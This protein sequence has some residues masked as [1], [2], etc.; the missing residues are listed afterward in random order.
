FVGH[1]DEL[2]V[3]ASVSSSGTYSCLVQADGFT[4]LEGHMHLRLRGPPTIKAQQVVGAREGRSAVLRCQAR[5]VPHPLAVTWTRDGTLINSD[6]GSHYHVTQEQQ[7]DGLVSTLIINKTI[8]VDFAKYNCSVVN[9]YG[10]DVKQIILQKQPS[11]PLMVIMGCGTGAVL[12]ILVVALFIICGRRAPR[13]ESKE[14]EAQV[15]MKI[16]GGNG[17]TNG[18]T[19]NMTHGTTVLNGMA[20]DTRSN[21]QDSDIKD[22]EIQRASSLSADERDSEAGWERDSN[23]SVLGDVKGLHQPRYSIAS[24]MFTQPHQ[25]YM[26]YVDYAREY[27]PVMNAGS[28]ESYAQFAMGGPYGRSTP[29]SSSNPPSSLSSSV[30]PPP[31]TSLPQSGVANGNLNNGHVTRN[32]HISHSTSSNILEHDLLN[33]VRISR[34]TS[35][36]IIKHDLLKDAL[37]DDVQDLDTAAL[38]SKY[39]I[40]PQVAKFKPGT[41]V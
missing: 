2:T 31:Y 33:D 4:P 35:N 8:G 29:S 19:S 7:A 27:S 10:I 18:V 16:P 17:V 20:P 12:V 40:A 15:E 36:N 24:N 14:Q 21:G 25:G 41:L 3:T 28:G 9:E 23:T 26:S 32:G 22:A 6:P 1:G 38:H 39:I 30:A 5:A 11:V 37:R 34:S 13:R